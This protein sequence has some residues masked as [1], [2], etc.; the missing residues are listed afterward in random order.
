[1]DC[2]KVL[3]QA[4]DYLDAE[5]AEEL[6]RCIE[7][8]FATC[9]NCRVYVDSV[10]RTIMLYRSEVPLDC[11]EQVRARLHAVLSYEYRRK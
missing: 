1:M 10:K 2:R 6:V 7:E 8:H 4:S 11:P 9:P 5:G 3:E